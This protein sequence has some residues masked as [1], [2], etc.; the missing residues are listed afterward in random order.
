MVL[1]PLRMT[2]DRA[3]GQTSFSLVYGAE[4]VIPTE[5]I[6]GSPRVLAY[7]EVAKDQH[8]L[9]MLCYSRRTVSGLLRVLHAISKPC[10]AITA[11]G[12]MLGVL[13][14]ATLSLGAFSPPRVQT[15]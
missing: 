3:T 6:C 7:N 14:K 11:T 12:F 10:I 8:R 15:S 2:L 5:L 13:R 9:A 1:W 4:A